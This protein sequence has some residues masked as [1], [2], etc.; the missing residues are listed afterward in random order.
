MNELNDE[1]L[2]LLLREHFSTELDGQLGRAPVAII[3][4]PPPVALAGCGQ[5]GRRRRLRFGGGDLRAVRL[6]PP[7]SRS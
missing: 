5:L 1:Q 3:A 2:D 7:C 4:I 6:R